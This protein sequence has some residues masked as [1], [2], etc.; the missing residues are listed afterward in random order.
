MFHTYGY[1]RYTWS[2]WIQHLGYQRP[3]HCND[4]KIREFE[5]IDTKNSSTANVVIYELLTEWFLGQNRRMGVLITPIALSHPLHHI[6]SRSRDKRRNL[7][8]RRCVASWLHWFWTVNSI[9]YMHIIY[10]SYTLSNWNK[11]FLRDVYISK[12]GVAMMVCWIIWYCYSFLLDFNF[13]L[14]SCMP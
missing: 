8:V 2:P 1:H 14:L 7:R 10:Y 3:F 5:M 11:L 13:V 12:V 4:S 6:R 9:Y